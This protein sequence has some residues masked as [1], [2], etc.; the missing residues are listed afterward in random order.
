MNTKLIP[1]VALLVLVPGAAF[2]L[3]AST[4]KTDY[5]WNQS[6]QITGNVNPVNTT[7]IV[8][9]WILHKNTWYAHQQVSEI[10]GTFATLITLLPEWA[11]DGTYT[12]R[13]DYNG[14]Q[15]KTPFNI[16]TLDPE[17]NAAPVQ[18]PASEPTPPIDAMVTEP[19]VEPQVQEPI[20][21]TPEPIV[22]QNTTT[23]APVTNQ[24]AIPT[25]PDTIP[26]WIKGVFVY[27]ANGQISDSELI[28]AI[29]FLVNTGVIVL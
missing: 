8:D 24:T 15:F 5:L 10:N 20:Q 6:I 4:D 11:G 14:E 25:V 1:L 13:V 18:E 9:V 7:N 19:V 22:V 23:T 21:I 3:D 28:E 2:A 26:S 16:L 12:V 27:W 17:P 29:R